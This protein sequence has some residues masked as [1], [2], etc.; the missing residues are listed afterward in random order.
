[1]TGNFRIAATVAAMLTLKAQPGG[2][3]ESEWSDE[4]KVL[5]YDATGRD[6]ISPLMRIGD[7]RKHGA[8][9]WPSLP[10]HGHRSTSLPVTHTP[11]HSA[12]E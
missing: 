9:H 11:P 1:M 10:A 12:Q 3:E 6:I 5:V 7:L 8:W 4:W 2:G